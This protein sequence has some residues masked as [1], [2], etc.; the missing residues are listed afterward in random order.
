[1]AVK[2]CKCLYILFCVLTV[3]CRAVTCQNGASY[4]LQNEGNKLFKL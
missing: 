2:Y 3:G 4:G 1:M